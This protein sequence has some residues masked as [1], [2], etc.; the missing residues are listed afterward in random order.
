[1]G[2]P[3]VTTEQILAYYDRDPEKL[4]SALLRVG[5]ELVAAEKRAEEAGRAHAQERGRFRV[6]AEKFT[7][8]CRLMGEP[9]DGFDPGFG[10]RVMT[11]LARFQPLVDA[12]QAYAACSGDRFAS[13]EEDDLHGAA[14]ALFADEV[15]HGSGEEPT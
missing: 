7:E 2:E 5:G 8:V 13:L 10:D 12:A 1:M 3:T 6:L 15:R 9:D 11:R 14:L 4:A